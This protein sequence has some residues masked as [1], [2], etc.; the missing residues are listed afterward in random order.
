MDT[1]GIALNVARNDIDW[2]QFLPLHYKRLIGFIKKYIS[3]RNDIDDIA[4]TTCLEAL[5]SW[6][7]YAGQSRPETWFFGIALNIIRSYYRQ[8]YRHLRVEPLS[9]TIE[10]TLSSGDD[11]FVNTLCHQQ[12]QTAIRYLE[13][14]PAN[15]SAMMEMIIDEGCYQ[16]IA[17]AQSI[18]VGTVRS[19]L[20]RTREALRQA[21]K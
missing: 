20:S 13:K 5:R 15:I 6:P 2:N 4:Q 16:D 9:E 12:M 11:P 7:S 18:P 21:I 17:L 10:L 1:Q 3:N 14:Q 8:H 19:R